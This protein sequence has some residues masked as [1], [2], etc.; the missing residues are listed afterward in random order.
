M[1]SW[2]KTERSWPVADEIQ[3]ANVIRIWRELDDEGKPFDPD[4]WVARVGPEGQ[5]K[6]APGANPIEAAIAL[7]SL[8]HNE[9]WPFDLGWQ[10][11]HV[12]QQRRFPPP[13]AAERPNP[14]A[15]HGAID[16]A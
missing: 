16:P 10:P 13:A 5:G 11:D 2:L 6:Q 12:R 1:R 14:T 7:V 9:R 15:V 8:C 3:D 4:R